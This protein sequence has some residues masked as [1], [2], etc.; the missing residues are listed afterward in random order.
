MSVICYLTVVVRDPLF[1]TGS[2]ASVIRHPTLVNLPV[3]FFPLWLTGVLDPLFRMGLLAY[4]IC[5][6][7]L[8]YW[9]P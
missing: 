2:L 6:L 9:R 8:I 4:V 3:P 7:T 1:Y 5:K